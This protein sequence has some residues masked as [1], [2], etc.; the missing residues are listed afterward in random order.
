MSELLD[1]VPQDDG[2][3]KPSG[4]YAQSWSVAEFARN[5]YQ[6]YL[7]F[8]PDLPAGVL[9]FV[10]AI[11]G[12]WTGLFARLPFGTGDAIEVDFT[13]AGAGQSWRL[14]A[15]AAQMVAFDLLD[16]ASRRVRV[17]FAVKPG[18]TALLTARPCAAHQHVRRP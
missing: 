9:R 14:S 3:L 18:V 5:G 16:T 7:G 8:R 10:P 11:P 15:T 12:A 2:S 6:D 4:T 13:R 17:R 1:A